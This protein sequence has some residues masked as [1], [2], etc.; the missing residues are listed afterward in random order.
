M[1]LALTVMLKLQAFVVVQ[2]D[3]FLF[4]PKV[5]LDDTWIRTENRILDLMIQGYNFLTSAHLF[6]T[7]ATYLIYL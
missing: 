6:L 2:D 3:K 1:A 4:I 5:I 7:T